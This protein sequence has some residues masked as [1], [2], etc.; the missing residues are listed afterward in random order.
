MSLCLL[1]SLGAKAQNQDE[2]IPIPNGSFENWSNGN[3]YSVTILV[4]PL[5]IYGSYTY[6]T[7]W[8]FPSFPI[9]ETFSYMGVNVNLNT[10]LPLMKVSKESNG[11]VDGNHAVN[12]QSFKISDLINPT[13]YAIIQSQLDSSIANAVFP[14]V[15]STGELDIMEFLPLIYSLSGGMSD[16]SQLLEMLDELDMNTFIHGGIPLNGSYP[17]RLTG[18]YKYSSPNGGDNGGVLMVGSRYNTTTHKRQVVGAGFS[19]GMGEASNFTPFEVDYFPLALLNPSSPYMEADSLVIFLFSSASVNAQQGSSLIV[20]NLQLWAGEAPIIDGISQLNDNQLS[21]YPNPAHGQC[22]VR[23]TN[24]LPQSV[25]LYTIEGKLIQEVI[26]SSETLQLS[27]PSKGIFI[28]C[29][30]TE[31]GV[32]TRKIVNR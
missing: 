16:I 6:P 31:S 10:N 23:F 29:C 1:V 30:E 12:L 27:L 17:A 28:L 13:V 11:V 8:N 20:D 15:L 3:G 14:T 18:S 32:L 2:L 25:K 22:V 7:N 9:D 5:E 21:I 4:L 26:P 24:E 19:M